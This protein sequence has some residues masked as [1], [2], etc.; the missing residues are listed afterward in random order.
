MIGGI[1]TPPPPRTHRQ[2]DELN[3]AW[4]VRYTSERRAGSGPR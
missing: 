3:E 2:S 1:T 4:V